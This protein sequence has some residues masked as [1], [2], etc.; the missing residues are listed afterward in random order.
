MRR[1][2]ALVAA[3]AGLALL[4]TSSALADPPEVET[5]VQKDV[6]IT[7]ENSEDRC[8]GEP[9]TTTLTF[10]I[11]FHTTEQG[12]GVFHQN[13]ALTGTFTFVPDDPSEPSYSGHFVS[14]GSIQATPP[15]AGF[16]RTFTSTEIAKTEDGLQRWQFKAHFTRLPSG[17]VVVDFVEMGCA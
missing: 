8:T 13:Q 10:N 14:V 7:F 17:E 5:D 4:A 11:V 3:I 9:G 15:G 2:I 6:T 16:V 1:F 12:P